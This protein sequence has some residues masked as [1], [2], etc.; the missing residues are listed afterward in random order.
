MRRGCVL[1]LLQD[2]GFWFDAGAIDLGDRR[3]AANLIAHAKY[4][5]LAPTS[6]QLALA[7]DFIAI[8]LDRF[9]QTNTGLLRSHRCIRK[10]S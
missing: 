6:R 7:V 10:G 2:R 3:I 5:G 8:P 1:Q 9:R 4:I